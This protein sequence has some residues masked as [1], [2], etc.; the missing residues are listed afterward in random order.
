MQI[1]TFPDISDLH[2]PAAGL[3]SAIGISVVA[4]STA[5]VATILAFMF[6]NHFKLTAGHQSSIGVV[7]YL[8]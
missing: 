5:G 4:L 8:R 7:S 1:L 2:H 3:H 6:S